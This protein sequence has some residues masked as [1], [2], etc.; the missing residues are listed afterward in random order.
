MKQHFVKRYV[1][2]AKKP[3]VRFG[4]TSCVGRRGPNVRLFAVQTSFGL[5]ALR[6]QR[7]SPS[8]GPHCSIANPRAMAAIG[9]SIIASGICH[10]LDQRGQLS[11]A[12]AIVPSR[13]G[14][15]MHQ[16]DEISGRIK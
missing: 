15:V 10:M 8:D 11:V 5:P 1:D 13:F 4:L 12:V 14:A 16:L 3:N 9:R 2:V 6:L 7:M